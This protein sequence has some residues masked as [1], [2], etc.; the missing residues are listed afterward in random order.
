MNANINISESILWPDNLNDK[1]YSGFTNIELEKVCDWHLQGYDLTLPYKPSRWLYW[2]VELYSF[3][4]C[5]RDWLN[6]PSWIPLPLY[7]DHGVDLSG[8]FA[9]HEKDAKPNTYLTFFKQRADN[10]TKYNKKLILQIQHPWI[11]YRRKYKINKKEESK[12]TIVFYSHSTFNIEI[13]NYDWDSYFKKIIM[14]PN[15]YHPIILCMHRHDIE[16]GYHKK[17]RKYNIPIVSAGET[18]SPYFIDR[19][20]SIVSKMKYATSN[21]G[22]SELFYCEELGVKYFILGDEPVYFNH[23]DNQ[24]PLGVIE[25]TENV[26]KVTNIRKKELFSKFPPQ[27]SAKKEQFIS[28][29]LGLDIDTIESKKE[30]KKA[31]LIEYL[32]HFPT[33]VIILITSL[34]LNFLPN[35]IINF[36][37]KVRNLKR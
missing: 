25:N 9:Q 21:S 18:S 37:R 22:G 12:G 17:L 28:E 6:L 36:L 19:F 32:R 8:E 26:N 13:I 27:R 31:L 16:K 29:L 35:F 24:S 3:G 11:T 34:L 2:T 5:Y 14:L 30:L 4:R 15:E 7:G 20:Y 1:I 33:I 10:L 23:G